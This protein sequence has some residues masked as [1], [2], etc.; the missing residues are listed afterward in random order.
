MY[1]TYD[2][3]LAEIGACNPGTSPLGQ[4][5]GERSGPFFGWKVVLGPAGSRHRGSLAG[6]E[7][8]QQHVFQNH[9]IFPGSAFISL[10]VEAVE[11]AQLSQVSWVDWELLSVL[12]L[13]EARTLTTTLAW[14]GSHGV[15]RFSS[16]AVQD[17]NLANVLHCKCSLESFEGVGTSA[18]VDEQLFSVPESRLYDDFARSGYYY[19]PSFRVTEAMAGHASARGKLP[20]SSNLFRLDPAVL[21]AALQLA[22]LVHPLGCLG[23]PRKIRRFIQRSGQRVAPNT[24]SVRVTKGEVH[25]EL[26]NAQVLYSLEGLEL[27]S[28]T[29]APMYTLFREEWQTAP[30]R[31]HGEMQP[32]EPLRVAGGFWRSRGEVFRTSCREAG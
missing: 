5:F 32:L 18:G 23:A 6:W 2:P 30:A 4:S 21:D 10:A 19:G 11:A 12:E 25:A 7:L 17:Q 26:S 13:S 3:R 22:S 29:A 1:S 15:I 28:L 31:Q 24:A 27:A 8:S 16:R 14:N 9:S 20:P